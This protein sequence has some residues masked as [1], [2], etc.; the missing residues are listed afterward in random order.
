MSGDP[1]DRRWVEQA[2]ALAVLGEGRTR[3]NPMVGC[4]VVRRGRVVGAGYH[5]ALGEP[6]AETVALEQAG[7]RARGA[8]LYV[9][10][11]PCAHHG[12]TPPCTEAIARA[13][14]RRVVASITDPNP[15]VNGRGFERLRAAGVVVDAGVLEGRARRVN[16]TFLHWHR[17]GRPWVTLKAASSL[18]GLLA[19]RE[20]RS[21]W[22]TGPL[23][24]R[25][26]HRC[27]LRHD[28]IVV[29]AETIRRDDP[30][31]TVRLPGVEA[32]PRI[33]VLA[34][35]LRLSPNA[36]IFRGATRP[37]VYGSLD[38]SGEAEAALRD[39]A[40]VRRVPAARGR[41]DLEAVVEDLGREG[42]QSVLVEGGG[43]TLA[44][45]LAGGLAH[46]AR[47]FLA[48]SLLGARGGTP[49]VDGDSVEDPG[50]GWRLEQVRRV[51]IGED[52]MVGG[53]L[54]GDPSG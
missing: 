20:G 41:V 11:E 4:V 3:P 18:D 23:A 31:L 15:L 33:V 10:L 1:E 16:R 37:L 6:H 44:S 47:L 12:R 40:E 36:K 8:T 17:T 38:A 50:W 34:S 46:E 52:E 24:R 54:A 48:P 13:G 14:V 5:R 19:T 9:N 30:R 26:A 32:H 42:L 28:A 49:V 27:R 29:G 21:R 53:I 35:E 45:F 51:V 2:L 25:V 7:E 22:I 39:R 43:K